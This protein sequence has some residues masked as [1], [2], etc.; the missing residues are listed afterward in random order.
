MR[1]GSD[2]AKHF[3]PGRVTAN[4]I[5]VLYTPLEIIPESTTSLPIFL[6][7]CI[8]TNLYLPFQPMG[9][10]AAAT[11][12]VPLSVASRLNCAAAFLVS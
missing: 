10:R 7:P 5:L 2:D 6:R 4:W 8:S 9:I 11:L 1:M 3:P 12:S